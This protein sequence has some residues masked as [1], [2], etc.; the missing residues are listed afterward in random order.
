MRFSAMSCEMPGYLSDIHLK[1]LGTPMI[2]V[3]VVVAVVVGWWVGCDD[4][5]APT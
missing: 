1:N 5:V 2:A 4:G 3:V